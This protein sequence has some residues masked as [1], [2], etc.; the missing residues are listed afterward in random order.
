MLSAGL[1]HDLERALAGVVAD[2]AEDH[3]RLLRELQ[4]CDVRVDA[5]RHAAYMTV[6]CAPTHTKSKRF[7]NSFCCICVEV[8]S[9]SRGLRGVSLRDDFL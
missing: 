9:M 8:P 6:L 2:L 7:E 4:A 5:M 1:R 3:R